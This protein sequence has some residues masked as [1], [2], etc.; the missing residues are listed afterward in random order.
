M[1]SSVV[2]AILL[3]QGSLSSV[4][5]WSHNSQTGIKIK[6]TISASQDNHLTAPSITDPSINSNI[7]RRDAIQNMFSTLILSQINP[8]PASASAAASESS[9][10]PASLQNYMYTNEWRGTSLQLLS[11]LEAAQTIQS[12]YE[13][14]RWPDPILRRPASAVVMS[15]MN[16]NVNYLTSIAQKLKR[17]ARE[18]GAVGLAAQQW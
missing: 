6:S 11:P 1:K 4:F 13:M 17:T 9:I 16:M 8:I 15:D 7:K 5:A 10:N 2:R 18:N 3:F 12:S 14:A